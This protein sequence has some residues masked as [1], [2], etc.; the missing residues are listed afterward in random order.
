MRPQ[1]M[2][3]KQTH[4]ALTAVLS[5]LAVLLAAAGVLSWM[6]LNDPN[7]G[8]GLENTQ[9]SNALALTAIQSAATGKE[10]SFS[11]AEVNAYL[12]Y[13]LTRSGSSGSGS[14]KVRG[15]AVTSIEGNS[16]EIYLPVTFRGRSIG[17]TLNVTP[18][19]DPADNRLRFLVNSIRVGHLPV[20]PEWALSAAKNRLPAGFSAEGTAVSYVLPKMEANAANVTARLTVS[21]LRAEDG[22]VKVGTKTAVSISG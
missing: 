3:P 5:I 19:A 14:L 7:A 16:A 1:H 17:I 6:V 9:P 21:S 18:S 22:A 4:R 12:A 11:P 8:K 2:Q 10:A 20:S 13:L 15:A